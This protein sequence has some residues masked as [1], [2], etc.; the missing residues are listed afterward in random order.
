MRI[1]IDIGGS[2]ISSG[3]I[4]KNGELLAKESRDVE[5]SNISDEERIKKMIFNII[6]NEIDTL[7]NKNDYS[8]SDILKIG[9]AVPR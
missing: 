7:L 4:K 8:A 6:K 9:V 3:I 2:H 5:I 1:G